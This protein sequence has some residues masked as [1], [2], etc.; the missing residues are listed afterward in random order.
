MTAH[1]YPH[2]LTRLSMVGCRRCKH[3]HGQL[4]DYHEGFNDGIETRD[5]V[6]VEQFLASLE[7]PT[8]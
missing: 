6:T 7:P 1:E 5:T 4:C 2:E 3:G 8:P